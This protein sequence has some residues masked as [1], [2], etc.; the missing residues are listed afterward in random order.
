MQASIEC[1]KT[2]KMVKEKTTNLLVCIKQNYLKNG[3]IRNF[4]QTKLREFVISQPALL[5]WSIKRNLQREE[6]IRV[7]NPGLHISKAKNMKGRK[8][9]SFSFKILNLVVTIQIA[10]M[11]LMIRAYL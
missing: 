4:R 9:K 8:V 7:R 10:T 5:A 3:A 2:F 1:S 6:M 11:Y